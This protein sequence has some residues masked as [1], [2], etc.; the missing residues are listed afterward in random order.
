MLPPPEENM[1]DLKDYVTTQEAAQLLGF[2]Q[3]TIR[4]LLR[5]HDLEGTKVRRDWLVLRSSLEEYVQRN[6]EM[7]KNDPR[8][9]K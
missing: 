7:A 3:D 8:R 2:H 5:N 6:A 9:N 4:R 1:P